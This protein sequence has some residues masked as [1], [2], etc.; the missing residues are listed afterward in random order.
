MD[1]EHGD[2]DHLLSTDLLRGGYAACRLEQIRLKVT[3]E[4]E[5]PILRRWRLD[6]ADL[7]QGA[8]QIGGGL[9][10]G[11]SG[12]GR[13]PEGATSVSPAEL[14]AVVLPGPLDQ[15]YG[16]GETRGGEAREAITK[17]VLE[18]A[19]SLVEIPGERLLLTGLEPD[20][21]D[22]LPRRGIVYVLAR[23]LPVPLG[24]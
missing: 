4:V 2:L 23:F 19:R 7:E 18:L 22:R 15:S 9:R 21:S 20:V 14:L 6:C 17:L 8:D 3:S 11:G 16:A 1:A 10:G 13:H 24:D 12:L 5:A